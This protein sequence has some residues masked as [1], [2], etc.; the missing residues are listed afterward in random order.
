MNRWKAAGFH[1]LVSLIVI[2]AV[3]AAMIGSWYGIELFSLMGAGRLIAVL[4]IINVLAG[5]FLTW[6]VFK[7]GKKHLRLDLA[8]IVLLQV[9]F[10]AWGLHFMWKSRPVFLVGVLDRF[11]LVFAD[12]LEREDLADGRRPE[13]RTLPA[14][15][16]RLVGAELGSTPEERMHF[17]LS[18][19]AGKDV[20]RFPR[21]F[22]PYPNVA[23]QILDRA[24][25]VEELIEQSADRQAQERIA[26]AVAATGLDPDEI[27]FVPITSRRGVATML[28]SAADGAV[29][30][31][32][33]INPWIDDAK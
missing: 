20:Q 21:Q 3:S 15:R 1:L 26:R 12:E 17:A 30:R 10:L 14:T 6:V 11:E 23:R 4:A 33:G 32:I 24:R 25:P 29:L 18:G 2:L 31:P 28:L 13:Y 16:P 22:V 7:P 27:V 19:L 8:I 9:G 5:P